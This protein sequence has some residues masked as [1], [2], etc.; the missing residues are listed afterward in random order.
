MPRIVVVGSYNRDLSFVLRRMPAGGETVIGA[1]LLEGPGGKGSNQAIQAALAGAD[2][3]ML[4]AVGADGAGRDALEIWR[5]AG[6]STRTV[7]RKA[8]IAT[9][10]AAILVEAGGENRIVVASGANAGLAAADIRRAGPAIRAAGLV[11]G[12]LE[13][14]I[15]ATK[16][17]FALARRAG[18]TTLL[19]TAPVSGRL[20]TSLLRLVDILVANEIEARVLT[21]LPARARPAELA[22]GLRR[23]AGRAAIVTI[24][25]AGA[26]LAADESRPVHFPAPKTKVVDT[27]GAGD[28]FVGA[29]AARYSRDGE[30]AAAMRWGIAAGSLACR[31]R[32]AAASYARRAAIAGL[33]GR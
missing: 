20:P 31:S 30:M 14:P 25:A 22:R 28:A 16:A 27:T 26:W 33:A 11:V 15:A 3:S 5:K 24:G 13:V 32:G 1:S 29:F 4:A 23:L 21:G 12:Q 6:I 18:A 2:I 7:V 10:S 8:G 17:A 19:N 9:G